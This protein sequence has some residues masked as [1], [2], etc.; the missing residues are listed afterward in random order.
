[1]GP[2]SR[3]R[4]L[5]GLRLMWVG[6]L[7]LRGALTVLLLYPWSSDARRMVMKQRWSA[8]MLNALGVRLEPRLEALSPASLVVANHISWLDIFV[9]N[10]AFPAA[11][12]SK[13]EVRHWP[14]I[15]WLAAVND[16]VFLRRGSRGHAR[17]INE[18]IGARLAAGK[19]VVLFPEGTTT[20]GTRVLHFHGALLQPAL[21][22]RC[23][24]VPL[25]LSYQDQDGQRS[26]APRYDG[27][28]SVGASLASI[29]ACPGLVARIQACPALQPEQAQRRE[30]AR[31]ARFAITQ[32]LGL[33]TDPEP[34]P[35]FS[36]PSGAGLPRRSNP[37]ETPAGLPDARRTDALPT[38]S[39]N[40]G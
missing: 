19:R 33:E 20:D 18:E 12:I 13:A 14:L 11:F 15:G 31:S 17:L 40:P 36:L 35:G 22:A 34:E 6:A 3:P 16:T 4:L 29:L 37:P 26:L 32:A 1:M 2:A 10:A 25:A 21:E 8:A 27:D 24:V 28:I 23:P 7:L 30:M 9:I 38:G 5:R 39:L